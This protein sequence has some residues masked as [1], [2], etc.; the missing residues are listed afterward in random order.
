MS[1][2]D[3][4]DHDVR[5]VR[6]SNSSTVVFRHENESIPIDLAVNTLE[7]SQLIQFQN[8]EVTLVCY[9]I[10]KDDQK[11][12]YHLRCVGSRFEAPIG[13]SS[14]VKLGFIPGESRVVIDWL[15][16]PKSSPMA[17][18]HQVA[19]LLTT[20]EQKVSSV[21]QEIQKVSQSTLELPVDTALERQTI[22]GHLRAITLEIQ[23]L[24]HRVTGLIQSIQILRRLAL[25]GW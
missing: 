4:S 10:S 20:L 1:Y 9:H 15:D 13:L 23:E 17:E 14:T 25:R 19:L 7:R 11:V 22:D 3:F 5:V 16:T 8:A 12:N 18:E 21:R 24:Q 6:G 2:E